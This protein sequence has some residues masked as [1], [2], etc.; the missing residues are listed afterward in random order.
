[1]KDRISQLMDG[2]LGGQDTDAALRAL[3]GEGEALDAWR[4]YHLISDAVRETP[5]LSAGFAARFSERLAAEP[6]V[7]APSRFPPRPR[8]ALA[9]AASLAGVA[10]V[11]WLAFAPQ[12]QPG[13]ANPAAKSPA[14][15][16]ALA[17]A[18]P[19]VPVVAVTTVLPRAA[20]DYLLAHQ[21]F[22]PRV[23]LQGMA[24]YVRTVSEPAEEPGK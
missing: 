9:A 2:E 19:K 15:S 8:L 13:A 3:R 14:Q 12:R 6:T 20:N 21:G 11:G 17:A 16:P 4:V 7:L 18:A 22:S 24:P 23:Y 10:L 1:M 5:L